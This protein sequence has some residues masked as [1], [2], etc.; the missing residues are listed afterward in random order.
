MLSS[1]M[2]MLIPNLIGMTIGCFG[3]A[4]LLI[5]SM[6]RFPMFS[7]GGLLGGLLGSLLRF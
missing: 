4:S 1:L 2:P 6:P 3:G 7:Y 5:A